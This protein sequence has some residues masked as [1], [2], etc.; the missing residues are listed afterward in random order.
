M[1]ILRLFALSLFSAAFFPAYAQPAAKLPSLTSDRSDDP[2][3]AVVNGEI[4]SQHDLDQRLKLTLLSSNL[5]DTPDMRSGVVAPLLR[6]LVDEDLKIQAA[7]REKITVSAA[8]IAT[9]I[10]NIEEQ[11]HLPTGS[12]AKMLAGKGIEME[13]LRQQVRAEIAWAKLVHYVLVRRVHVSENAVSTRLDAIRANLGKP[14]YHVFEIYLRLDE[15]KDEPGV[16]DLAGRL[17]EQM[18]QGAP[19]TAIARQFN[20]AGAVDGDLGWMSDGMLDDEL[21]A[22]LARLQPNGVTPPI[23]TPDG[24][25]ILM[26][27]EKRK[28][29][30]GLGGGAAVD[31]MIIDLKSLASAGQA[32][33]DL[34]MQH[35]REAL[36]PAKSCDDL[37]S[38]SKQVPSAAIE[39]MEKLPET[40][41]PAKVIPLIKDLAPGQVSE[42]IDTAKGRRLFAVCGRTSGNAE[43]LP[44][45]DDIRHRM[46]DEQLEL[47]SRRYLLDLHA[48]AI[49]DI[50]Q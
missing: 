26:L 5:P 2:V 16:R 31:L 46:E 23:R 34:Q 37:T 14:E 33:R 4:I 1:K 11:N 17:S 39:I 25:H 43:G 44:S 8:D 36:A 47:L 50:R 29:G 45:A 27:Q 35:L 40:Q 13:A 24:Y 19:F 21:M 7:T 6:R 18:R 20:Q 15:G 3:A 12:L 41:V 30:E 10:E 22:A 48:T 9:Q 42:P 49:V 32:E 28:V 38:L